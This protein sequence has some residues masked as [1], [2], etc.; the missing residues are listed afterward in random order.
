[1]QLDTKG[2]WLVGRVVDAVTNKPINEARIIIR[3]AD[4]PKKFLGT[5]SNQTDVKGG[6]NLLV[7]NFPVTVTVSAPGYEDWSYGNGELDD[8]ASAL[9]LSSGETKD[10]TVSLRPAR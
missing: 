3:H 10:V 8:R 4:D 7:P 2:A 9:H 1:M 6:F 5:R